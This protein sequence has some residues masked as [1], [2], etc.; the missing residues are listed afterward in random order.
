MIR[1][2]DALV[3]AHTK[4]RTHKI[5][6][7]IVIAVSGL[8][9]GLI[10][11]F[12]IVAQ[13]VFDSVDRFSDEGLNNR[14]IVSVSRFSQNANYSEYD[15]KSD[16]E[17][18]AEVEAEHKAMVTNKQA[19][20]KKYNVFYNAL[21]MDPSPIGI[22]PTT[23]QKVV[24][25]SGLSSTAVQKVVS[26]KRTIQYKP[27]DINAYIAPYSSASVIGFNEPLQPAKGSVLYMKNDKEAYGNQKDTQQ[28]PGMNADEPFITV[29]NGS[30]T[31]PF[32]SVDT[33]DV[34]KG[35]VPAIFPYATAEKLLGLEPYPQTAS[36]SD[37]LNRLA[38]VRS[39]IGE[40]TASYCYR[41]QASAA[42]LA[43]AIAQRDEVARNAGNKDYQ[44]PKLM[45]TVPSEDDCGE[46]VIAS[47]TRTV[48]EK[49]AEANQVL[50]EKE[51]GTYEGD[52]EQHKIVVRGI[53]VVN[54]AN[55]TASS[56]VTGLVQS[57]LGS[58]LGYGTIIIPDDMLAQLPQ[59][60]RPS[61]VFESKIDPASL[62]YPPVETY[63]VEFT[64]KEQARTLMQK[65]GATIGGASSGDIFVMPYGSGVLIID[66]LRSYFERILLWAFLAIGAV[67]VIILGSM[68]GR[69]VAEGRRESA[70]F[71]AI[72]AK[73]SDIGAIYGTYAL[74]L[75]LR[76]VL[77][78][79]VMAIV[80][81]LVVEV[82]F[83]NDATLGARL[84][85]AASDTSREFHLFSLNSIYLLFIIVTIVISSLIAS[86]IPILLGARR[87]PIKD[88]RDDT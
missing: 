51:T 67:A 39:R 44:K 87:S 45:Y 72:G 2:S 48:S 50:F 64:E 69:T 12:I 1:F 46:V 58:W 10:A 77:F 22:D 68:I 25:D 7:G 26:A 49:K 14:T 33:F 81:A 16:P 61:S 73:R 43:Q 84:A 27:F 37:K 66:E 24:T 56:S 63:L 15:H 78:T 52:P 53:G 8:S 41:N 42:L 29:L 30:L 20:A 74:L 6:T 86:I 36:T 88:M 75:G 3:L 57:L 60:V 79:A 19:A 5:R 62:P 80:I 18:I 71:R 9:F 13:G 82:L 70:V 17:F 40:V 4:L 21:S 65:T 85:Y 76:T 83:W 55:N 34:T 23:K 11:A 31:K 47:D 54:D 38:E 59:D 35:E 32:I 28:F